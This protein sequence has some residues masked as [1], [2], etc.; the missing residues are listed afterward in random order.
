MNAESLRRQMRGLVVL[1]GALQ[2]PQRPEDEL[3]PVPADRAALVAKP[4][5]GRSE[6]VGPSVELVEQRARSC[7][8]RS[9]SLKP[10]VSLRL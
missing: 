8:R 3:H 1:R 7:L 5:K 10:R 9:A 6:F 4:H 2:L